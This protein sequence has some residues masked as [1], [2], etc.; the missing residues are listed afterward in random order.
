M[1]EQLICMKCDRKRI[2]VDMNESCPYCRIAT[3]EAQLEAV[4]KCHPV[5]MD[6]QDGIAYPVIAERGEWLRKS[7]VL[8]AINPD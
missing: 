5:Y 7:D 4:G 8:A 3:L 1:G 6:V 2:S